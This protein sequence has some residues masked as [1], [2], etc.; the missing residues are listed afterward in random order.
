M[1]RTKQPTRAAAAR[2]RGTKTASGKTPA[3]GNTA[4]KNPRARARAPVTAKQTTGKRGP[5]GRPLP[6]GVKKPHRYRPG[7]VS[8]REIRRYQKSTD[9]LIAK[10]PYVRVIRELA[11]KHKTYDD[12][13]YRWQGAAILARQT[14]AEDYLT[15]QFEDANVC[16]IHSKRCTIMPKDIQLVRRIKGEETVNTNKNAELYKNCNEWA[17]TIKENDKKTDERDSIKEKMDRKKKERQ[18]KKSSPG[19]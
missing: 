14:A 13:E 3:S 2:A 8:L 9:L 5:K 19:R 10:G 11:R 7:T 15:R 18:A 4:V 16:A 12:G 6:G 1:A 17:S